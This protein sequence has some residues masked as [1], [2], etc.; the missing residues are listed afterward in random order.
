M[1]RNQATKTNHYFQSTTK[2]EIEYYL[3]TTYLKVNLLPVTNH[4]N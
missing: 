3:P 1:K 4:P 2:I